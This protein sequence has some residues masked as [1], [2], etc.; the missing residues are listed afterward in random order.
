MV[1]RPEPWSAGSINSERVCGKRAAN[2][3]LG[4]TRCAKCSR[5]EPLTLRVMNNCDSGVAE[6]QSVW[7]K[8]TETAGFPR[9]LACGSCPSPTSRR[10]ANAQEVNHVCWL[11]LTR[12][13]NL[14][15]RIEASASE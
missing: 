4:E 12:S 6:T 7:S 2:N 11:A 10:S 13:L 5:A 3:F 15:A 9:I 14:Q 8:E 1:L